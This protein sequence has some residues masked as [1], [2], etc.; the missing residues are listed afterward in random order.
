V[1][2]SPWAAFGMGTAFIVVQSDC[3]GQTPQY[4]LDLSVDCGADCMVSATRRLSDCVPDNTL[5][6]PVHTNRIGCK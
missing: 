1:G 2:H 3:T 4:F 5:C 6:A